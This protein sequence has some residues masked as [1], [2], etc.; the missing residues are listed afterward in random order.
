M[1]RQRIGDR[2]EPKI[3][4]D[5]IPVIKNRFSGPYDVLFSIDVT[6]RVKCPP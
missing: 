3:A 5:K 1:F 2:S 6:S 4:S